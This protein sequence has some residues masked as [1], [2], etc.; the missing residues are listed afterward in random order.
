[1]SKESSACGIVLPSYCSTE[2]RAS[3]LARTSTPESDGRLRQID[4]MKDEFLA[5]TS[6]EL[7]TPLNGII[8][9]AESLLD[10]ATG[11]LGPATRGNLAMLATSGQPCGITGYPISD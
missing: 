3:G 9:I 11:E 6:H 7:R 8:G 5:N 2:I 1:M 4:H 10:G